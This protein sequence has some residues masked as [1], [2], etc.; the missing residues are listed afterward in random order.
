MY[1]KKLLCK[2]LGHDIEGQKIEAVFSSGGRKGADEL[3]NRIAY[4]MRECKR[5][6]RRQPVSEEDARYQ[7][8]MNANI[9]A[10]MVPYWGSKKPYDLSDGP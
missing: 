4:H 2:L 7:A 6:H 8:D 10:Q 1:K 3:G 9:Q 5:C